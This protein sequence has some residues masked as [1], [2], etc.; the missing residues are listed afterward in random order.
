[1]GRAYHTHRREKKREVQ[2]VV[3]KP[4]K[5]ARGRLGDN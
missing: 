5:R 1:M 2:T 4:T 3:R